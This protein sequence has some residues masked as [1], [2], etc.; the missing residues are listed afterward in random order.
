MQFGCHAS[1][2]FVN[3]MVTMISNHCNYPVQVFIIDYDDCDGWFFVLVSNHD[4]HDNDMGSYSS[5]KEKWSKCHMSLAFV[6]KMVTM[7]VMVVMVVM[8]AWQYFWGWSLYDHLRRILDDHSRGRFL[9][10]LIIFLGMLLYM[11]IFGGSLMIILRDGSPCWWSSLMSWKGCWYSLSFCYYLL[12]S[13]VIIFIII[14][15]Y[16]LLSFV[17]I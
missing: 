9:L 16:F 13:F 3:K 11:I 14:C 5:K 2:A 6:N 10:L 17:I 15:Y 8:Q 4:N 12:L 7:I 1:L